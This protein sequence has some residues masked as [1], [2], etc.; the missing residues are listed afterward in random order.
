MFAHGTEADDSIWIVV[1]F[2]LVLLHTSVGRQRTVAEAALELFL[3]T[4]QS[5]SASQWQRSVVLHLL[6]DD[7]RLSEL[8]SFRSERQFAWNMRCRAESRAGC[9]CLN[10]DLI[11]IHI[12]IA[13]QQ[14]FHDFRDLLD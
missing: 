3:F 12:W 5:S 8:R 2:I 14:H 13:F 11:D 9:S 1:A 4:D 6:L 10:L 7:R